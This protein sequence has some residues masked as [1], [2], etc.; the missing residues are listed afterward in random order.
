VFWCVGGK[1][2]AAA[3]AAAVHAVAH[4]SSNAR[5]TFRMADT[6]TE[7]PRSLRR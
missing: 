5:D 7:K 4:G 1:R 3:A 2:A 6:S